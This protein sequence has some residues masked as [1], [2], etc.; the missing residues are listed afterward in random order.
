M[1]YS[2]LQPRQAKG[3]RMAGKSVQSLAFFL[4]LAL[5]IYVATLGGA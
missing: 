4:L 3:A 5:T 2:M 1:L